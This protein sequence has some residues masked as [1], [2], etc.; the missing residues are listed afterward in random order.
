MGITGLLGLGIMALLLVLQVVFQV[1]ALGANF[2]MTN[3]LPKAITGI[4]LLITLSLTPLSS[5]FQKKDQ[6]VRST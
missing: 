1:L 3:F 4:A 5:L 6:E 2:L